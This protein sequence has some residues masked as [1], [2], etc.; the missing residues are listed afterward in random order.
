MG[1]HGRTEGYLRSACCTWPGAFVHGWQ[2]AAAGRSGGNGDQ[3]VRLEG[4]EVE[5]SGADH[6][7]WLM[8]VGCRSQTVALV[9]L[10]AEI[11]LYIVTWD[12]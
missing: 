11:L 6:S 3:E 9:G 7:R 10:N 4:A 8:E 12:S 2:C 5:M 1:F